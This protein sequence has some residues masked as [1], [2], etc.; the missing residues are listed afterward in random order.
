M[1]ERYVAYVS[2]YTKGND[3]GIRIYDVDVKKG[4]L[5]EREQVTITNSSYV[6]ISHNQQYVYSITDM[7]VEAFRIQADGGLQSI[8]MA[9]ING[10]RGC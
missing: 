3:K 7:G 9:G 6:T 8:N 5:I 1:E 2:T 10:M 4:R